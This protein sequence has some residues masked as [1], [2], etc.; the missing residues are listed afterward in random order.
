[1]K[2]DSV[3]YNTV[4]NYMFE[5]QKGE[6]SKLPSKTIPDQSMTIS[7]IVTRFAKGLPISG[8]HQQPIWEGENP[9]LPPNFGKLD[10]VD[11]REIIKNLQTKLSQSQKDLA[12]KQREAADKKRKADFDKAVEKAVKDKQ[13]MP[14]N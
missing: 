2:K 10:I 6:A 8:N 14:A 7:E 11:Q 1:M 4:G 9:I 5:R 3:T 13:A 12:I